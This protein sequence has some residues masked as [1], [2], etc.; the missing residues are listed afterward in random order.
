MTASAIALGV[1]LGVAYTLSPLTVVFALV[2]AGAGFLAVRD[3]PPRERRWVEAALMVAVGARLLAL[4]LLLLATDPVREPFLAWFP[5]ARYVIA[6][7]WRIRNLWFDV[8]IGPM[9][10]FGLYD[11]YAASSFP[12][13]LAVVQT[14]FGLAPY[15]VDLISA[16]ALIGGALVLFRPA[17][18]AYGLAAAVP[19]LV[20][21]LF[22]PTMFAWSLS[23]LREATQFFLVAVALAGTVAAVRQRHWCRRALGAAGAAAATYGVAALRAEALIL[24][25]LAIPFGLV[26]RLSTLRWWT[27]I[28]A[29]TVTLAV[30]LAL[31]ARPDVRAFVDH[32]TDLAANR[33]WG[34]VNTPGRSFKLLD[35]RIYKGGPEATFTMTRGEAARFFARSAAAFVLMPLPWQVGSLPELAIVPQQLVWYATVMLAIFGLRTAWRQDALLTALLAGYSVA[36]L[37]VIAPNSGNIGTLVRHRDMVTPVVLWLAGVGLAALVAL[38]RRT[39]SPTPSRAPRLSGDRRPML[40]RLNPID[41]FVAV[42]FALTVG[43]SA[44]SV[45]VF[46]MPPPAIDNVKPP[47]LEDVRHRLRLEGH[48]FRQYLRVFLSPTGR[49]LVLSDPIHHN[50]EALFVMHT[51]AEAELEVPAGTAPGIYDLYV[52]DEGREVARRPAAFSVAVP[53]GPARRAGMSE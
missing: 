35:E 7:S 17:R 12:Y 44:A 41:A 46:R 19:A 23:A 28:A 42:A 21:V 27:S 29:V 24:L 11:T 14:V 20:A 50:S 49:P 40:G 51:R 31:G 43:V 1:G 30:G 9:Y 6:R 15:G 13:F 3:L 10:L 36:G 32:Q 53:A 4:A 25:A 48:D 52:Y 47:A 16:A 37:I 8:P 22:W 18:Q 26:L 45:R 34:Q 5:D 39:R 33:H 2:V 38:A